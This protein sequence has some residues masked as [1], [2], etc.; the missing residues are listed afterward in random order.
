M[1][2]TKSLNYNWLQKLIIQNYSHIK[3]LTI[4]LEGNSVIGIF[5]ANGT[6]KT[7]VL[8][9]IQCLY[10][11]TKDSAQKLKSQNRVEY[12][13]SVLG[14]FVKKSISTP[15]L[16]TADFSDSKL[17]AE[18]V[19]TLSYKYSEEQ[20]RWTPRNESKPYRDV[21][22]VGLSSCVP[23]KEERKNCG[24]K[25]RRKRFYIST[26]SNQD[27]ISASIASILGNEFANFSLSKGADNRLELYKNGTP[28]FVEDL[29]AGE[30]RLLRILDYLYTV[31][32]NSI[33]LIDEIEQ[34][35]HPRALNTLVDIIIKVAEN[36]KLQVIFTS[37]NLDLLS[38]TDIATY[39]L[40]ITA[41]H[42]ISIV[43]GSVPRCIEQLKGEFDA[44][45]VFFV[46]DDLSRCI[47]EYLLK[48]TNLRKRVKIISVGSYTK[49]FMVATTLLTINK[50]T[51]KMVFILD[52]DV[53]KTEGERLKQL[54]SWKTYGEW[55]E[56][57]KKRLLGQF[58]EY[59]LTTV[60]KNPE[61]LIYNHLC[62]SK[63][64][65]AY[66]TAAKNIPS[67]T[68]PPQLAVRVNEKAIK[69]LIE[70]QKKHYHIEAIMK[71]VGETNKETAMRDIIM[72]C[73]QDS[74]F[75]NDLTANVRDWMNKNGLLE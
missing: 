30:Q 46:E 4:D 71:E 28:L 54:E 53:C 8:R 70:Y 25:K 68:I 44:D 34:T 69:D 7:S 74:K 47:I 52:G 1:K 56:D 41:N 20:K 5:G 50:L 62:E 6:G 73:V 72:L 16:C 60:G 32:E 55:N 51:D 42:D 11:P 64:Q 10:Q 58:V 48:E 15:F 66:V 37:H 65:N 49:L 59:G 18:K 23:E 38:R 33:I 36:R 19:N 31:P 21:Y 29:S 2:D 14:N 67:Y 63:L 26:T 24:T 75:W 9:L 40:Y 45:Y 17:N 61:M 13:N 57:K 12:H 43:K 3:S 35:L 39:S 22:Y 27:V